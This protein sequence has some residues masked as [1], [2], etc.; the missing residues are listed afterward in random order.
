MDGPTSGAQRTEGA[1]AIGVRPAIGS[2]HLQPIII[3]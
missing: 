1:F 2:L 3:S